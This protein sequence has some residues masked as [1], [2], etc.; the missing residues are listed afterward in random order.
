MSLGGPVII[1]LDEAISVFNDDFSDSSVT[2]EKFL[3]VSLPGI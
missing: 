1:K 2:L 3:D